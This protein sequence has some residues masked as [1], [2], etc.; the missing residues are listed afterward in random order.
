MRT[1]RDLIAYA[2]TFA[3]IMPVGFWADS[4]LTGKWY[5]DTPIWVVF[6]ATAMVGG[7][8]FRALVE[9]IANRMVKTPAE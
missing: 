3:V 1:F 8:Y 7:Y 5:I 6:L 9:V 4:L 2:T